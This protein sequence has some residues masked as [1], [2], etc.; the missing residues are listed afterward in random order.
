MK[1]LIIKSVLVFALLF[2]FSCKKEIVITR[3]YIYNA[4]WGSKNNP[5][6]F[7]ISRLIGNKSYLSFDSISS[8]FDIYNLI[9]KKEVKVDSTFSY[10]IKLNSSENIK[11]VYFNKKQQSIHFGSYYHGRYKSFDTIG[12]LK[13]DMWYWIANLEMQKEYYV[14]VHKNGDLTIWKISPGS[15]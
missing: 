2:L 8:G 3:D 12:V 15:W 1:V 9:K 4:N 6:N 14:Y 7:S 13:S 5:T 10:Y 11:K